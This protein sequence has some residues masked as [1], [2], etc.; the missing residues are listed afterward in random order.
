M[1]SEQAHLHIIIAG[2]GLGGLAAAV[3]CALAG[4]TVE[5]VEQAKELVEVSDVQEVPHCC[6]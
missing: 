2:A 5:V 6:F 3:S 4:H 1:V